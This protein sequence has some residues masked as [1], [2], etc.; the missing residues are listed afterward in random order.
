MR[1]YIE[2][3][4]KKIGEEVEIAGW[5][6]K[7]VNIG[8]LRFIHLRDWTGV[9]Q[10]IIKKGLVEEKLLDLKLGNEWVIKVNGVV[11]ENKQAINGVE[12]VPKKIE[13]ISKVEEKLPID[14]EEKIKPELD[15]RLYYRYLDLRR[16]KVQAIFKLKSIVI[17]AFREKLLDIGFIEINTPTIVSTATEGGAELFKIEYFENEAFLSQSPQ[18]YK[19]LAVVGGLEKV[20]ITTPIYRAE[21][22]N[23]ITHLNEAMSLDVE[24]GFVDHF[25]VMDVEEEVFKYMVNKANESDVNKKMN[26]GI[27]KIEKI[28]RYTYDKI[29]KILN[30][31]GIKKEWGEDFSKEDEQKM[32]EIIGED[33]FFIYNFPSKIR[34]FYSMPYEDNEEICKS[35]DLMYKGVEISSGAQRIHIPEL[36]EKEIKKRGLKTKDFEFYINAFKFGSPPHG[37]FALGLERIMMKLTNEKNIREVMMF[38]RDRTRIFP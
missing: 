20:F 23:T 31:N 27:K 22:F 16:E 10:I 29:I 38:P 18:L 9:I 1:I 34:A 5:I 25:K 2:D 26:Y 35:F 15:T 3:A 7:I 33:A 28:K 13:I 37:G 24:M 30:E 14:F 32:Y 11:K 19:Q 36:L 6:K 21:K 4:L 8:K 17:N 12:L